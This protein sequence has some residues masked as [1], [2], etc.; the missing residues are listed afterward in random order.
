[1]IPF[2]LTIRTGPGERLVELTKRLY[3]NAALTRMIAACNQLKRTSP[4]SNTDLELP[5]GLQLD[6]TILET[7]VREKI[8]GLSERSVKEH[9]QG[10]QEANALV[11]RGDY[12]E[13]PLR[14]LR[15]LAQ[16]T[17]SDQLI[18]E[19]FKLLAVAYVAMDRHG[20]AVESFKE[21]LLRDPKLDLDVVTTSPKV[22]RAFVD[23]RMAREGK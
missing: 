9:R 5:F 11:R 14:L 23:A 2:V 17:H 19:T 20:L 21:A 4:T 6:S 10:L 12:W 13:V 3:G 16:E 7:L 22:L 8:L 1:M 18:A 15:L